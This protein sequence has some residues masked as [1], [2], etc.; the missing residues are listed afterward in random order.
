M[1]PS[2][3]EGYLQAVWLDDSRPVRI[4]QGLVEIN[5][6]GYKR[7]TVGVQREGPER[8]E[9]AEVRDMNRI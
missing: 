2:W 3:V 9:G 1:L 8:R 5:R 4:V 7:R 6:Q